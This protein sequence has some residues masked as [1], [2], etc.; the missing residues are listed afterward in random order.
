MFAA[1]SLRDWRGKKVID[2]TD[3][4]KIFSHYELPYVAG[5]AGERRLARR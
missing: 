5:A 1:E 2:P 3:E 4:P